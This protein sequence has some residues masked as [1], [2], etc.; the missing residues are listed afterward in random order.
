M[1]CALD[2]DR[3]IVVTMVDMVAISA[4]FGLLYSKKLFDKTYD[5]HKFCRH[6]KPFL[7][8]LIWPFIQPCI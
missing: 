5:D 7:L 6:F 1:D 2:D 4:Q 8:C 3:T